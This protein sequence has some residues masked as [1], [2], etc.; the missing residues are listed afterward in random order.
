M[1]VCPYTEKFI[2]AKEEKQRLEN[3]ESNKKTWFSGIRKDDQ[4]YPT[5]PCRVIKVPKDVFQQMKRET[6]KESEFNNPFYS[7]IADVVTY[8]NNHTLKGRA[9]YRMKML[10]E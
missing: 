2:K 5:P 8:I 6:L 10:A 1:I 7:N 9:A 3:I 4:K